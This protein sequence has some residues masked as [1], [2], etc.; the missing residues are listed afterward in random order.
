MPGHLGSDYVVGRIRGGVEL[1]ATKIAAQLR[2][3]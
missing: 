3:K 1:V 2:D